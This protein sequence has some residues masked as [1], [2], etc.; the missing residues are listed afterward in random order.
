MW[1]H[2]SSKCQQ[3]ALVAPPVYLARSA[4][5]RKTRSLQ[6]EAPEFP[7]I[8]P[9]AFSDATR[10]RG[11]VKDSERVRRFWGNTDPHV[12]RCGRGA[13]LNP[14]S[15]SR[16]ARRRAAR[17]PPE[18]AGGGGPVLRPPPRASYSRYQHGHTCDLSSTTCPSRWNSTPRRRPGNSPPD[19]TVAS[20]AY[21]PEVD[22]AALDVGV[23]ELHPHPM[24]YVETG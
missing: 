2:P 10:A 12:R 3:R 16:V 17:R 15:V 19:S 4:L 20:V 6:K 14:R 11:T 7:M 5:S 8:A 23:H 9:P 13:A 21:P 22:E 1:Y 18:A 24:A